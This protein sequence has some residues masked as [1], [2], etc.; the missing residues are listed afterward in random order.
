M[1]MS[2]LAN[3]G[4]IQVLPSP[5]TKSLKLTRHKTLEIGVTDHV[6]SPELH[7]SRTQN[8]NQTKAK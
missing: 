2:S 5:C 6:T 7:R 1:V 3:F 8:I 4:G